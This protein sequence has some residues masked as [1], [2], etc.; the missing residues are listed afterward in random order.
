[1]HSIPTTTQLAVALQFLATGSFQTVV[2]SSHGISQSSVS[3]CIRTVTD[4]LWYYAT[5]YIEFP[6]QAEQLINQQRFY[7]RSGFPLLI[8][9][10]DGTHVPILAPPQNED[11]FVNRKNFHSINIQAISDCNL[12]FIDIIAKWPGG[13]HEAFIWRSS[14]VNHNIANVEIPVTNGWFLGDSGYPL[15]P[16]LLTPILSPE[17]PDQRRH[18]RAFVK[19]RKN[20]EFDLESGKLDGDRW[21][22]QEVHCYFPGRVCR[23]AVE[24]ILLHNVCFD[25]DL[26]WETTLL[27]KRMI[28]LIPQIHQFRKYSA[29]VCNFRLL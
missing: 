5:E 2:A 13:T 18:N 26:Q 20:I 6:N 12:K 22:K 4:A 24:T 16:N 15:R 7:E 23:L 27:Q 1:M 17:T 14:G 11:V 21:T 25:H 29:T 9:S 8:G 3:R 10:I 28:S 19:A